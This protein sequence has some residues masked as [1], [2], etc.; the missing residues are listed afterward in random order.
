MLK[1]LV[2]SAFLAATF[3]IA[4][5][6]STQTTADERTPT[7]TEDALSGTYTDKSGSYRYIDTHDDYA[8]TE[9]VD[10]S[11]FLYFKRV[12]GKRAVGLTMDCA[13][14]DAPNAYNVLDVLKR[15]NVRITF[16]IAGPFIFKSPSAGLAG[17]LLPESLP[18]IRRMIE[19]G[20]EF[21]SHSNTHPHNNQSID[22]VRENS[23]LLRGWNA[24]IAKIYGNSAPP[25][26][27]AMLNVWRAPYGEYDA[28]SLG[29]AGK[30][31]FPYHF[32]WNVDV[33]DAVG[34]PDCK[35]DPNVKC[36]SPKK[37]T[38]TVIGFG[39]RN[40]WSLDGFVILSHLQ[41]PYMW[42]GSADGLD[43]LIATVEGKDHVIAKLSDMFVQ[44][45]QPVASASVVTAPAPGTAGAACA[46][47]CI[48]SSFCVERNAS[49]KR[50]GTAAAPLVCVKSGGDCSVECAV[51]K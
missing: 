24:A 45:P 31:G 46:P 5:G 40:N 36:L 17:G 10:R 9:V 15:R 6:C 12:N 30:A 3:A 23:E 25:K 13:W 22:W 32:G 7:F 11:K 8:N 2:S 35:K 41:N 20:H 29:L 44:A 19:D 16:F 48:Y 28:R 42:G 4:A 33:K 14:V 21:G 38:D 34:Y 49:A 43:R 50:Y 51:T 26:N 39:D 27:S 47:G 18:I 37:L 1:P